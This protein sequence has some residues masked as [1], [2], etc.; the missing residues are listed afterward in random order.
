MKEIG[1]SVLPSPRPS[2]SLHAKILLFLRGGGDEAGQAP[3]AVS[4]SIIALL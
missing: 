1:L 4:L 2:R 3:R